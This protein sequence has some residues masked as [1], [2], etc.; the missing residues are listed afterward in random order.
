MC[1]REESLA[2]ALPLPKHAAGDGHDGFGSRNLLAPRGPHVVVRDVARLP[3]R[4]G[5]RPILAARA[6][7]HH[8]R[9]EQGIVMRQPFLAA[10]VVLRL[11]RGKYNPVVE[12][13]AVMRAAGTAG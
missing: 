7:Q 10:V 12:L 3:L 11:P 8:V 4:Q 2:W 13:N 1:C 9:P 6:R 5:Q